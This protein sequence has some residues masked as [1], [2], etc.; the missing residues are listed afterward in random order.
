MTG[1]PWCPA[2]A[3]SAS[4]LGHVTSFSAYHPLRRTGPAFHLQESCVSA[5]VSDLPK[6][7]QLS[8]ERQDLDQDLVASRLDRDH[9]D[10]CCAPFICGVW[11]HS[12]G[13]RPGS[14][15]G[16]YYGS[17]RCPQILSWTRHVAVNSSCPSTPASPA[18]IFIRG[19]RGTGRFWLLSATQ[20][21]QATGVWQS[22]RSQD[23]ALTPRRPAPS[24]DPFPAPA[25]IY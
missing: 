19:D 21:T 2:S 8:S 12:P 13:L 22:F 11:P 20:P 18:I 25:N 1:P 5:R 6:A 4:A 24:T 9:A 17:S 23:S 3:V 7:T 16:G 10:G 15:T 14:A